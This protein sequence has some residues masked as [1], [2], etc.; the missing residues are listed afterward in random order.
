MNVNQLRERFTK[1]SIDELVA[2]LDHAEEPTAE[3]R[4]EFDRADIV[5]DVR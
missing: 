3:S 1:L 4:K 5:R 2:R